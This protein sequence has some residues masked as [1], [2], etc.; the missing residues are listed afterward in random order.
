MK[1][2]GKYGVIN[3]NGNELVPIE[4]DQIDVDDYYRENE[5]YKKAGYIVGQ[6]TDEGYRYGYID[7]KGNKV[8]KVEYNEMER[9]TDIQEDAIYLIASKNG[10]YGVLKM[11]M[12]Y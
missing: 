12:K 6:K 10:Q 2:D 8:T 11:K 4:Y 1:K 9:I 7:V 5:G 3:I